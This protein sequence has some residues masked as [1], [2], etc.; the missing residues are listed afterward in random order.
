MQQHA[1]HAWAGGPAGCSA[2][3][4]LGQAGKPGCRSHM[5]LAASSRLQ[6]RVVC[7]R[8]KGA[9]PPVASHRMPVRRGVCPTPSFASRTCACRVWAVLWCHGF[10]TTSPSCRCRCAAPR[11]HRCH[12]LMRQRSP[13]CSLSLSVAADEQPVALRLPCA[14]WKRSPAK[15]KEPR[16]PP[17]PSIARR[18]AGGGPVL[19]PRLR[20]CLPGR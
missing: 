11:C 9:A 17:S 1:P 5:R 12:H 15:P 3:S 13:L 10:C 4:L 14:W 18:G 20:G 2:G 7:A 16:P 6:H 19:L 8:A